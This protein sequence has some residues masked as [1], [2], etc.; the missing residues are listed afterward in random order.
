MRLCLSRSQCPCT[1]KPLPEQALELWCL[2]SCLA[3]LLLLD[4]LTDGLHVHGL[5]AP[6][7]QLLSATVWAVFLVLGQDTE[8]TSPGAVHTS[9]LHHRT[10]AARLGLHDL[11]RAKIAS[12]FVA[13]PPAGVLVIIRRIRSW[14]TIKQVAE[15]LEQ[16]EK[17]RPM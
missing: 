14:M 7:Q 5:L 2:S 17:D 13:V 8:G 15:I 12:I 6:R 1:L 4:C 9:K 11:Q 3:E 16:Q 10:E